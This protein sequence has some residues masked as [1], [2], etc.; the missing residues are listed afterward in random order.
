MDRYD[1]CGLLLSLFQELVNLNGHQI[2]F[3]QCSSKTDGCIEGNLILFIPKIRREERYLKV[4]SSD[5]GKNNGQITY[6]LNY[7]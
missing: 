2:I 6:I 5:L 3:I 4:V 7:Y 1:F